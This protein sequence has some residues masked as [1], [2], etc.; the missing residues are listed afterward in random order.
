MT[1]L[2]EWVCNRC[3]DRVCKCQIP[4]DMY[5]HQALECITFVPEWRVVGVV[6]QPEEINTSFLRELVRDALLT[7]GEHHLRWYLVRIA[8]EVKANIEDIEDRGIAP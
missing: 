6:S 7:D 2:I 1:E 4:P 5:P 3:D 8:D